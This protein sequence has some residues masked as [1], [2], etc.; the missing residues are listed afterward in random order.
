M[1][2]KKI[3]STMTA[4]SLLL[5]PSTKVYANDMF[6]MDSMNMGMIDDFSMDMI[7]DQ[8]N[9]AID[10]GNLSIDN[11]ISVND[12]NFVTDFYFLDFGM[13]LSSSAADAFI[14]NSWTS[15]FDDFFNSDTAELNTNIDF[16]EMNNLNFPETNMELSF[17]DGISEIDSIIDT[18]LLSENIDL[19]SDF[20]NLET[21]N[22]L[23]NDN[24]ININIEPEFS[25]ET[26]EPDNDIEN[27]N[28]LPNSNDINGIIPE[29]EEE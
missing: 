19:P 1:N 14:D 11:A 15:E 29:N 24:D 26:I 25:N 16:I 18:G 2:I 20:N 4:L 6:G 13:D 27:N 5:L 17:N 10:F 23:F 12:M 7:M 22:D 8:S 3:I 21:S 9:M 28:E